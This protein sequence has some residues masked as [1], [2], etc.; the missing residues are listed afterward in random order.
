[1]LGFAVL[2]AIPSSLSAQVLA[3]STFV[4]SD[5]AFKFDYPNSLILCRPDPRQSDS[6]RPSEDCTGYSSVCGTAV[7]CLAY[8][9]ADYAGSTFEGASFAVEVLKDKATE[10]AC[11]RNLP[12][13]DGHKADSE[14]INGVKFSVGH[15]AGVGMGN[16]N[17]NYIYRAFR[18]SRCYQ[19]S[20]NIDEQNSTAYDP[21]DFPKGFDAVEYRKVRASLEEV[22]VT[23]KFLGMKE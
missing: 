8:P 19:L 13:E 7:A 18:E 23:F 20:I 17:D 9:A 14:I 6:W 3:F 5:K 2:S 21:G 10:D 12:K 1:V 16:V 4:S 11:I 15:Y 22:L